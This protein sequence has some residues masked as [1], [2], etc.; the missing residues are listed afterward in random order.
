MGIAGGGVKWMQ[1]D[2]PLCS[3]FARRN[4]V[5]VMPAVHLVIYTLR[6]LRQG[7]GVKDFAVLGYLG[8]DEKAHGA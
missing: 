7:V 6:C 4:A 5:P 1:V 2:G 8:G 3:V